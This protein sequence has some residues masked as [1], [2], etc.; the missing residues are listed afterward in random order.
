MIQRMLGRSAA[1]TNELLRSNAVAIVVMKRQ[2]LAAFER[3]MAS[4]YDEGSLSLNGYFDS[5]IL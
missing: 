5:M 4:A 3:G 2:S 1:E